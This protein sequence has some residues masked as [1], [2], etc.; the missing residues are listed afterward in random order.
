L[1]YEGLCQQYRKIV[2]CGIAGHG[3]TSLVDLGLPVEMGDLDVALR[4]T[5][6]GAMG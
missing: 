2:P 3:V 5:F 4:R 6:G 1:V